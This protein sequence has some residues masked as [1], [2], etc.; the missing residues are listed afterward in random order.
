MA[1][2]SIFLGEFMFH[3]EIWSLYKDVFQ[4]DSMIQ[5]MLLRQD[6]SLTDSIFHIWRST[7][8]LR[9]DAEWMNLLY[10]DEW[11]NEESGLNH[12]MQYARFFSKDQVKNDLMMYMHARNRI[13]SYFDVLN[14]RNQDINFVFDSN[15]KLSVSAIDILKLTKEWLVNE[16]IFQNSISYE[17]RMCSN[18][19]DEAK[20]MLQDYEEMIEQ[21]D[22]EISYQKSKQ[23]WSC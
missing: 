8:S 1:T 14:G 12:V 2:D 6:P 5:Q 4:P 15:Y 17:Y 13:I 16:P 10:L 18:I 23:V 20:Y 11:S 22:K 21:I 3:E 9:S 7:S 19:F